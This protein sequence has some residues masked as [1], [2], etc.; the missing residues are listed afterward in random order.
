[1]LNVG[2]IGGKDS[3]QA[4][5]ILINI[6]KSKG[7]SIGVE[8]VYLNKPPKTKFDVLIYLSGY[9]VKNNNPRRLFTFLKEKNILIVNSDDESVFPFSINS[10]TT[11]ITCGLNSKSSVTASSIECLSEVETIQFCIQRTIKTFSGVSLEPQEFQVNADR[12]KSVNTVL[13]TVTAAMVFD[14]E[15]SD[16]NL[17]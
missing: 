15:I 9:N 13:A 5:D 11:L 1:M 8:K 10:G 3:F 4:V 7:L 2:I 16:L 6:Y 17:L 12:K 14:T